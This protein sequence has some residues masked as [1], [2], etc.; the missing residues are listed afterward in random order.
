MRRIVVIAGPNGAGKSTTAPAIVRKAF[1]IHEFVNADDIAQG[2]SAFDPHRAAFRAGRVML[3]Q[4]R[5]LAAEGRSFAFETTLAS[6]SFA[7]WL[8]TWRDQGY[9]IHI[10]YLW[11]PSAA[12]AVKRVRERVRLGGHNVPATIVRR[13]YGRSLANFVNLYLPIADSWL[14]LDN[15]V[16]PSPMAIA[17]RD[18]RGPVRSAPGGTWERIRRK[19]E[20]DH[21][22]AR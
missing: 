4:I 14:L 15:S 5:Q 9:R 21:T 13:R 19:H 10:I 12:V 8:R 20:T 7:P 16:Q 18:P 1:D 6:R 11:L 17:W 22:R 2:L 3:G